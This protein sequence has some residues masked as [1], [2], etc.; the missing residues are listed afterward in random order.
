VR[1][2]A[3]RLP[4]FRVSPAVEGRL[5]TVAF[6]GVG[7]KVLW[8]V[9]CAVVCGLF[10][11]IASG[12]FFGNHFDDATLL[13]F[14][15]PLNGF[16]LTFLGSMRKFWPRIDTSISGFCHGGIWDNGSIKR[17]KESS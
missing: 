11:A 17:G 6:L 13:Y 16:G 14:L 4:A 2:V 15:K 9:D 10:N 5:L 12:L 7:P 1:F 8:R 3:R